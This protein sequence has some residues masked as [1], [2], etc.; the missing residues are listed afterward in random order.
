MN[1]CFI[2]SQK[3]KRWKRRNE[4]FFGIFIHCWGKLTG[5]C[6]WRN[7]QG[8]PTK[9]IF[10]W[11]F[12]AEKNRTNMM[13]TFLFWWLSR[14]FEDYVRLESYLGMNSCWWCAF[15]V[16]ICKN[17]L[18][19]LWASYVLKKIVLLSRTGRLEF[20]PKTFPGY[21]LAPTYASISHILFWSKPQRL[22]HKFW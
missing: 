7:I 14:W 17:F 5:V 18:I 10:N 19:L 16:W 1:W 6:I 3:R 2:L 9:I 15:W 20:D 13:K 8:V 12:W 22:I 11:R 4:F 21:D